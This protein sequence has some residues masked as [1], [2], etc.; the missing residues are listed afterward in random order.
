M[1]GSDLAHGT[2]TYY[3]GEYGASRSVLVPD[4]TFLWAAYA[5]SGTKLACGAPDGSRTVSTSL[6]RT[7]RLWDPTNEVCRLLGYYEHICIPTVLASHLNAMSVL[8]DC[9]RGIR[10]RLV[11]MSVADMGLLLVLQ[12]VLIWAHCT[13]REHRS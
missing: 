9:A 11:L 13:T 5:L 1:P 4:R 12:L 3:Q 8:N 2:T 10:I 7:M 6:D